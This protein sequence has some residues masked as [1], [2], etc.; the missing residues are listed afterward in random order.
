MRSARR[1]AGRRVC[2][3]PRLVLRRLRRRVRQRGPVAHVSMHDDDG[4][5]GDRAAQAVRPLPDV[6]PRH[7]RRRSRYDLATDATK[8]LTLVF[9]GYTHCPD[10]CQVVMAN[11][12]SALTRL[13]DAQ[14]AQVG[15]VFVTTDPAR[16]D[17]ATLRAYLDRF[18]PSLRGL[19]GD[20]PEIVRA[21]RCVRRRDREGPEARLRRVRRRAR[22]PDHRPRARRHGA[23]R[24]DR[25]HR[26]RHAR[27][28]HHHDPRRQGAAACE[29]ALHP[30]PEQGRLAPRPAPD[31]RLRAVHHRSASSSRSGSASGAG[32]PAAAS[33]ARS[34]TSR[35]G[36]CRSAS[37][38]AGSTT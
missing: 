3:R 7:R 19:T 14:R 24:L 2:R 11:I 23:V 13:D 17:A 20:L 6:D 38:A 15:M 12:A 35:S 4:L 31:P 34:P 37:S 8:P 1:A 26:P 32:S 21:R 22:H 18:D 30:Q 5:H 36:R 9:F 29:P 10:I 33:A 28:R 27:R 25:G 16:D